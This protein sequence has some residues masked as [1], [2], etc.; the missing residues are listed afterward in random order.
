M[1]RA[2]KEAGIRRIT[3]HG[4]RRTWN[5]LARQLADRMVVRSIVGHTSEAMTEHYSHV[6]LDEKRAAAEA[7][8]RLVRSEDGTGSHA[9]AAE[10]HVDVALGCGTP[11]A[12]TAGEAENPQ[13]FCG[14][15]TRI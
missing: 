8:A 3:T 12:A 10:C 7:V 13:E 4:F 1:D 6:A 14:G 9:S 2:C 5:N 11:A 15:A